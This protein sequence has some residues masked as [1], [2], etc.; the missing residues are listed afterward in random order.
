[1]TNARELLNYISPDNYDVWL[2]IGAALKHEGESLD[3]YRE[4]SMQSHKY[5]DGDCE[6]KWDSFNESTSTIVTGGTIYQMAVEGGYKPEKGEAL[7][8]HDLWLD[9][10][11][12]DTAFVSPESVPEPTANYDAKGDMLEYLTELFEPDE[13][14]GICTQFYLD[15]DG[16]WKPSGH[17]QNRTAGDIIGKLKS[18][19]VKMALGTLNEKAGVYVRF[20]PLD[21]QGENNRNVTRRT[22]CL[23]ESDTDS[24][25][26]QYSLL[27]AMNLPIRFLIH[28]GG[29]SL[30]AIVHVDAVN[31]AQY[32]ERVNK[33]YQFCKK[34]GLTPDE[35]DKNESRYS[36]L[37]GVKRAGAWQYIVGRNLGA[38]NYAEWEK[39]AAEQVDDLPDDVSY[40]SVMNNL[41]PLKPELIPGVLRVGHKML[42][43]GPSKAGKSFLL[44]N[45]CIS[46]AE[47]IEWLGMPCKQGRVLY[48]N[49]EL[50]EDSCFHRIAEIYKKLDIEPR[51]P[52]NLQ[53]WNLRGHAVPMNRLAPLLIQ[54][55]KEKHYEA[56]V[57]DPI[58]KVITGDENNATE[59]S[60]FCS[61]F[62]QV[63]TEMGVSVIYCHHHSKGA[64]GKYANAADRSSGSGV[65]ARD[66]D[67]ILD[68]SQIKTEGLEEK[69]KATYSDACEEL[70]AWELSGT[71]REFPPMK[72]KRLWFDYP[73]H[74]IDEYNYLA[75]ATYADSGTGGV[76]KGQK[77]KA[78]WYEIA[79]NLIDMKPVDTCATVDEIGTSD[80]NAKNVFSASKTDWMCVKLNDVT[81]V[82]KRSDE[83]IYM[84]K[85]Y[86]KGPKSNSSWASV[87][88][89]E[90]DGQ[91]TFFE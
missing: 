32:R 78:N 11:I 24:I 41:P 31:E 57:I 27:K 76:G 58:Y 29:K 50:D 91:R 68:L 42:L 70:T 19:S 43:A 14:V 88:R 72:F 6:K 77:K 83:V 75:S 28:S 74:R 20:N 46:I 35:Q 21:G 10:A 36:R 63:A 73:I 15:E 86:K 17:G 16:K 82:A 66:P 30:H 90:A 64:T 85:I 33:L 55:F 4:W 22:Y 25:E 59:M 37:P 7:D 89:V 47:G 38:A 12:I 71:L 62:D 60:Q 3:L 9:E 53:I 39:W 1:M 23:I 79:E 40:A 49:L 56:V 13:Y 65:F 61:Y 5:K 51:Y 67:A 45:L 26:K 80:G 81:V 2:K 8:I 84:G 44:I 34:N 48:V 87:G 69:Y 52:Q 54:R 18:G